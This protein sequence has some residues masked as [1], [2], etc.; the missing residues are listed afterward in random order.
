MFQAVPLCLEMEGLGDCDPGYIFPW[1]QEGVHNIQE[2][3]NSQPS[4]MPNYQYN[5]VWETGKFLVEGEEE[6]TLD[7]SSTSTILSYSSY[8]P[9]PIQNARLTILPQRQQSLETGLENLDCLESGP[10]VAS[11]TASTSL[12][13]E[14]EKRVRARPRPDPLA[15][16][17]ERPCRV[18]G[19]R[20]GKHS[21]YGGQV[22]PSCRA[23]FRRSVQSGYN[24]TYYCVKEGN[25]E[26]TLKTRKNCQYCRYRLCENAGMKTSW[27]LTEEERKLKFAGKGKKRKDRVSSGSGSLSQSDCPE[28]QEPGLMPV[29]E[30][31]ETDMADIRNYVNIS[32]CY[33]HSRVTDMDTQLIRKIIR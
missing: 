6:E 21:Y 24:A 4:V 3:L 31:C 15:R 11:V 25:C 1:E 27:V 30:L 16:E 17:T 33:E 12:V 20:A 28:A 23:F 32:G 19:E 26:V 10:V 5:P 13:E 18:C 2:A 14:R 8:S 22:C 7:L 29:L 9:P